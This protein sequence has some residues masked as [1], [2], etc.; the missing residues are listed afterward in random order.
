MPLPEDN[1]S[2]DDLDP[3]SF[4]RH[5]AQRIADLEASVDMWRDPQKPE[6]ERYVVRELLLNL[7]QRFVESDIVAVSRTDEPPDVRYKNARFEV[8][9]LY[10]KGR[11]RDREFKA[12]LEAAKAA[13]T[14]AE[15][16]SLE[17]YE[18]ITVTLAQVLSAVESLEA[19]HSQRYDRALVPTLDLL[20]YHNLTDVMGLIEKP[21]PDTT[22]LQAQNWRSVSVVMGHRALVFCASASAPLFLG[23]AVGRVAHRP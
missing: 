19:D 9:E 3:Q 4:A 21:Y 5:K 20:I 23:A 7:G 12:A 10:D 22:S 17:E 15:L 1:D 2:C 18:P 8:K 14:C 16:Y 13:T 11:T 6:R